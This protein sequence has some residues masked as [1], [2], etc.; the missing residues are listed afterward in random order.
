MTESTATVPDIEITLAQKDPASRTFTVTVPVERVRAAED[1][2]GRWYGKRTK[3]GGV[4]KGPG[5][6]EPAKAP[7]KP[8]ADRRPPDPHPPVGGRRACDVRALGG[9]EAGDRA[10]ARG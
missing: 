5:A 10:R 4:R 6:R 2:T 3:G 8:K 1:E 7:G 9:R